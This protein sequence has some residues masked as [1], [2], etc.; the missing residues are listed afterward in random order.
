M[1][2]SLELNNVK[3]VPVETYG[4]IRAK[5]A[6]HIREKKGENVIQS[7]VTGNQ[8]PPT[9]ENS[10][11]HDT[12]HGDTPGQRDI[13]TSNEPVF[14]KKRTRR[15]VGAPAQ[16]E[17]SGS[18][19][20]KNTGSQQ[21]PESSSATQAEN[22]ASTSQPHH[23]TISST[24]AAWT[25]S[26][27]TPPTMPDDGLHQLYPGAPLLAGGT[28]TTLSTMPAWHYTTQYPEGYPHQIYP[29]AP[30]A[31][32]MSSR[33]TQ[34]NML[35]LL[36]NAS[37]VPAT[38]Q[39]PHSQISGPLSSA[40]SQQAAA[41]FTL[42]PYI[43]SHSISMVSPYTNT[44]RASTQRYICPPDQVYYPTQ[45]GNLPG[46]PLIQ[47]DY[48]HIA[49]AQSQFSLPRMWPSSGDQH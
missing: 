41:N 15:K 26:Y 32:L 9:V 27:P 4:E 29:H 35:T 21:Q 49:S 33:H 18:R 36:V 7:D 34:D 17:G 48:S 25:G 10:G 30:L 47:V 19:K 46:P 38:P 28:H 40:A 22:Q 6:K 8:A 44:H 31:A 11:G 23:S 45:P 42:L 5:A 13:S 14:E 37:S 2:T 39:H 1:P 3:R 24:S 16:A 20:R 43:S 12:Q